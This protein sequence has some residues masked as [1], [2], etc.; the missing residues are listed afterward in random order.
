C[1]R[2]E[3]FQHLLAYGSSRVV[4][5][6]VLQNFVSFC[7]PPQS[8]LRLRRPVQRVFAKQRIALRLDEQADG[9]PR[10]VLHVFVITKSQRGTRTPDV[11]V[12]LGGK[13]REFFVSAGHGI[14][15]LARELGQF[16]LRGFVFRRIGRDLRLGR[17][18]LASRAAGRRL[19]LFRFALV[20][21]RLPNGVKH[22]AERQ[23]KN[24]QQR[25][26]RPCHSKT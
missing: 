11:S 2:P 5:Q 25:D 10:K 18:R 24:E 8:A 4:V 26:D 1:G 6:K 7:V 13:R 20:L 17:F 19:R 9:L 14:V 12:V 15:Q 16:L 22:P 23:R 21:G 3:S